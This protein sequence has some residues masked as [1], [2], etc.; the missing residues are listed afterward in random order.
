MPSSPNVGVRPKTGIFG[1]VGPPGRPLAGFRGPAFSAAPGTWTWNTEVGEYKRLLVI[2][3][4]CLDGVWKCRG[5]RGGRWVFSRPV[6]ELQA[7]ITW[8]EDDQTTVRL[9]S[10]QQF[11][12]NAF[13]CDLSPRATFWRSLLDTALHVHCI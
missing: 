1:P 11:E 5:G 12:R 7:H 9:S 2:V 13:S 3:F 4:D 10:G 8:W 6:F